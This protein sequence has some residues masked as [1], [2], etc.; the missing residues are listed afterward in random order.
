[1]MYVYVAAEKA[2]D[3]RE[4]DRGRDSR[5]RN[6]RNERERNKDCQCSIDSEGV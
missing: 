5:D 6:D 4:E 1:M 2:G 3:H